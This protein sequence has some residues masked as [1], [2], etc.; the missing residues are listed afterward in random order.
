MVV[1][2]DDVRARE[3]ARA[4]ELG[5]AVM[6]Q[7]PTEHQEAEADRFA[8]EFLMPAATIRDQL[9]ALT[10]PKLAR[11]KAEWGA[12]M[13]ALLRRG[14]DLGRVNDAQY[15]ALNESHCTTIVDFKNGDIQTMSLE[16]KNFLDSVLVGSGNVLD[17]T[18]ASDAADRAKP[19]NLLYWTVDQLV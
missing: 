18:E 14:R 11:L 5:H 3:R 13:A 12:S 1:G 9:D 4:H 6:H 16:L 10:V 2:R 7:I 19:F 17:A 8:S 15:R